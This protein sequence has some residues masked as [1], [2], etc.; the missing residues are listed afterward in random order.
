M[1]FRFLVKTILL[2]VMFTNSIVFA[3]EFKGTSEYYIADIQTKNTAIIF[4]RDIAKQSALEQAGAFVSSLSLS[5][6][7]L[8]QKDDIKSIFYPKISLKIKIP[9]KF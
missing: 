5:S 2:L 8:L 6:K 7:G 4:A 3:K 9:N 1:L